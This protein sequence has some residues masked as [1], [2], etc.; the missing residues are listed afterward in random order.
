M[1]I[2]F[3]LLIC[4]IECINMDYSRDVKMLLKAIK[5]KE[6]QNMKSEKKKSD[7]AEDVIRR[8]KRIEQKIQENYGKK[9]EE[10]INEL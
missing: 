3:R 9:L 7:L 10:D 4:D 8:E 1:F 5:D 2:V 6:Q